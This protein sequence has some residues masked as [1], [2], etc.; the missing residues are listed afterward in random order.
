MSSN[1]Q[2]QSATEHLLQ[3][4]LIYTHN[5]ANANTAE[6][7]RTS[8][9]LQAIVEL[10]VERG[11]LE[12]EVLEARAARASEKLRQAYLDKGMAVAM[13]EFGVSK[14]EFQGGAKIDCAS[15][16][17]LCGAACCRLPFALSQQDVREGIVKWDL[18]QPYINARGVDGTCVHLERSSGCC[19]VYKQRPIP[20]RGYDCRQDKRIW[21][22]FDR[23]VINPELTN[24]NWPECLES[25]TTSSS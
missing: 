17:E 12:T 20:C 19:D 15:R 7:H 13:Q 10:L 6:V 3:R 5:R 21:L 8:A 24:P 14:Y 16:I 2:Q 25:S 4:G 23:R 11:I 22:D 9:T 1:P 18:G